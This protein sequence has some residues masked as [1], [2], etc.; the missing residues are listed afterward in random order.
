MISKYLMST[1][2]THP[3]WT[4]V[5]SK[6]KVK[7]RSTCSKCIPRHDGTTVRGCAQNEALSSNRLEIG[8]TDLK[9]PVSIRYAERRQDVRTIEEAA[10]GYADPEQLAGDCA[11]RIA[12]QDVHGCS[13]A[14][15]VRDHQRGHVPL[16]KVA[17]G[18]YRQAWPFGVHRNDEGNVGA[19]L[20]R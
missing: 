5:G 3:S 20:N 2:D 13:T 8:G 12:G 14:P 17:Y 16:S 19:V 4:K 11:A 9:R 15:L 10:C 1:T 6:Q 18:R 7:L